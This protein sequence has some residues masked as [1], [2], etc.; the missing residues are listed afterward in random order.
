MR[1]LRKINS[2][3]PKLT[4]PSGISVEREKEREQGE[5]GEGEDIMRKRYERYRIKPCL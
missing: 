1:S 4:F 5:N 2:H 3:V